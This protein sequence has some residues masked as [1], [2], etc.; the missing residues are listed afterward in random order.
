MK[1]IFLI[2]PLSRVSKN[3]YDSLYTTCTLCSPHT[4]G[5]SLYTMCTLCSPHTRF[6]HAFIALQGRKLQLKLK[7]GSYK[8]NNQNADLYISKIHP[9]QISQHLVDLCGIL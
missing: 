4:Q 7:V 2:L 5:I 6:T 8:A 9:V 3:K 1:I